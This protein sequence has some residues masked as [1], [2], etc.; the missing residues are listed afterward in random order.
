MKLGI[1]SYTPSSNE[2]GDEADGP[3]DTS[4]KLHEEVVQI[5]IAS[6]TFSL[7]ACTQ[8]LRGGGPCHQLLE[9]EDS[10]LVYR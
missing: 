8:S 2:S 7:P 6:T 1:Q 4:N 9:E 10:G 5:L 3:E